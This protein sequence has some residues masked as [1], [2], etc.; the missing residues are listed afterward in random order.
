MGGSL[1]FVLAV[2]TFVAGIVVG[3]VYHLAVNNLP[4]PSASE[5]S[6]GQAS[7]SPADRDPVLDDLSTMQGNPNPLASEAFSRRSAH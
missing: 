3:L 5:C 4:A 6:P 1:V 2:A 7:G